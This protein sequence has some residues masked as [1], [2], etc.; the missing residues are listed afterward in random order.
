MAI[1]FN[2]KIVGVKTALKLLILLKVSALSLFFNYVHANENDTIVI[3]THIEPPLVYIKNGEFSGTNVAVAKR[4]AAAIGKKATFIYCPFARCLSMTK[5]GKA[6]MMVAINKTPKRQEYLDY[7]TQP[8]SSKI[9]P[10]RFYIKKGRQININQYEDL[11]GLN[12]GVLRGATYFPRFDND[13]LLNKVEITTHRQLI[14]MLLK[15]RIDTFLGRELSIKKQVS[16]DIYN[17]QL[18]VTPYIYNKKNDSYI[19]I[20]KKS[21]AKLDVNQLS[22]I[23]DSLLADGTIA[24][25]IEVEL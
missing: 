15:N 3:A 7:L 4:L 5:D 6:D 21:A 17:V 25:L 11:Q 12:I 2:F 18:A 8:F 14:E 23:L 20:S 1:I 9:T 13:Q 19:A 16:E 22:I 24:K 10:V